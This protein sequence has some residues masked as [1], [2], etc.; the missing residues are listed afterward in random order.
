MF[1]GVLVLVAAVAVAAVVMFLLTEDE[2][3]RLLTCPEE[4]AERPAPARCERNLAFADIAEQA[5]FV[6]LVPATLP[7]GVRRANVARLVMSSVPGGNISGAEVSFSV[8]TA[9]GAVTCWES[10]DRGVDSRPPD[11][12]EQMGPH[13]VDIFDGGSGSLQRAGVFV[14]GA[15]AVRYS[16]FVGDGFTDD[17]LRTVVGSMR[18][19][20]PSD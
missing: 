11:R 6:P 12:T 7:P 8:G 17:D 2:E 18:P 14:S 16:G 19:L 5:G 10:E 1:T 9:G 15:V 3:T 13:T 4:L 20:Q